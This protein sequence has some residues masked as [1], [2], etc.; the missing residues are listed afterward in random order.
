L[1][2]CC[3]R[4]YNFGKQPALHPS[5]SLA[6]KKLHN[7]RPLQLNV[8]TLAQPVQ[9]QEM[10]VANFPSALFRLFRKLIN[11]RVDTLY[12]NLLELSGQSYKL[13]L[14]SSIKKERFMSHKNEALGA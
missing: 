13:F 11:I 10:L 8:L 12:K 7:P 14:N 1:P 2:H 4:R 3:C 9:L 5:L 6:R